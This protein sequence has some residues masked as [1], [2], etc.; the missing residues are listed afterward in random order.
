MKEAYKQPLPSGISLQVF[1]NND[2]IFSSSGKWLHPL[3]D[4][5]NFLQTYKGKTDNLSAHDT[6]IGKAAAV[7]M[8]HSG[9]KK[10]HANLVSQLAVD[11]V[12]QKNQSNNNEFIE[13]EWDSLV[14]RLKCQTEIQMENLTDTE[15]MY[16]LLKERLENIK[17]TAK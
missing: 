8:L 17:K 4:F 12:K 9:I 14:D 7:L 2:L 5:E 1:N 13:L 16:F 10:I 15:E 6:A 3:F 11:F